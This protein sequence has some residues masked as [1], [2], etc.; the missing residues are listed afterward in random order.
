M[1]AFDHLPS[2]KKQGAGSPFDS[3]PGEAPEGVDPSQIDLNAPVGSEGFMGGVAGLGR[4]FA[5]GIISDLPKMVGEGINF[6]ADRPTEVGNAITEFGNQM[7]KATPGLNT[8]IIGQREA[9]NEWSVRGAAEKAGQ[10]AALSWGPGLAGAGV[11]A[12]AGS[13]IPGI[14]TIG[15]AGLGFIAG[16]LASLPFMAGQQG[17]ESQKKIEKAQLEKGATPEEAHDAARTGG[18]INAGI[19]GGMELAADAIPFKKILEPLAVIGKPIAKAAVRSIFEGGLKKAAKTVAATEAG[20]ISTEMMQQ[21]GESAVEGHFGAG[22][23]ATW[24]DTAQVILPTAIMS[25]FPGGFAAAHNFATVQQVKKTLGNG[26]ADPEARGAAAS[27]VFSQLKDEHPQAAQAFALY[28]RDQILAGRPVEIKDDDW[29]GD[30][31]VGKAKAQQFPTPDAPTNLLE[32]PG[33]ARLG[34]NP[35]DEDR[36]AAI[37]AA[38]AHADA[39]YAARDDFETQRAEWEA[40]NAEAAAVAGQPAAD[41]ELLAGLIN[42]QAAEAD[43]RA[44]AIELARQEALPSRQAGLDPAQGPITAMAAHAMDTGAT[45]LAAETR[46]GPIAQAE[47]ETHQTNIE[48]AAK[49]AAKGAPAGQ[50]KAATAPTSAPAAQ[51]PAAAAPAARTPPAPGWSREPMPTSFFPFPNAEG[52]A[53]RATALSQSLGEPYVAIPHPYQHDKFTVVPQAHE[54]AVMALQGGRAIP[55]APAA[56]AQPAAPARDDKSKSPEVKVPTPEAKT[57]TPEVKTAAPEAKQETAA[58]PP[59]PRKLEVKTKIVSAAAPWKAGPNQHTAADV[60]N[61]LV[62]GDNSGVDAIKDPD[63]RQALIERKM[64]GPKGLTP[65][66]AALRNSL[67]GD[68]SITSEGL[69]RQDAQAI[70]DRELGLKPP[71]ATAEEFHAADAAAE[72]AY[73]RSGGKGAWPEILDAITGDTDKPGGWDFENAGE[74]GRRVALLRAKEK[75]WQANADE[76]QTN[77]TRRALARDD[78]QEAAIAGPAA[79]QLEKT[80]ALPAPNPALDE[81]AHEAATSPKNDLAPPTKDQQAAG[82]YQK[83][84][85]TIGGL[86]FSI[87]NPEG[88]K[89]RPEWPALKHHYGYIKGTVGRDKD[90]LDAFIHPDTPDDYNGPV[91]IIDQIDPKT[92]KFDEHKIMVGFNTQQQAEFG[93]LDNYERGWKGLGDI[94]RVEWEGFKRW[95]K[96]GNTKAPFAPQHG[97]PAALPPVKAEVKKYEPAAGDNPVTTTGDVNPDVIPLEMDVSDFNEITDEW[98]AMFQPPGDERV[99]MADVVKGMEL[100]TPEQVAAQLEQWKEHAA[101]Q[102]AANSDRWVISLFDWTGQWS[103]PWVEAG[104][105]VIHLDLQDGVDI[106]DLSVEWFSENYPELTDVWAI[107]AAPPCTDF[108]SS[109]ARWMKEKDEDGRTAASI[110][111]VTQTLATIEYFRPAIWALENPV[112][113]IA[114]MTG[115]PP[116]RLTFDPNHFGDPYTKKTLLWG[117]FDAHLPALPVEATDGSKMHSKYGGKSQATKNARS[118]TPEGFAWSFFMQNNAEDM[119]PA[120]RLALLY[121]DASGAIKT[122][123]EAG[124]TAK[125]V[126]RIADE[127]YNYDDA[128]ETRDALAAAVKEKRGEAERPGLAKMK[129]AKAKLESPAADSIVNNEAPRIDAAPDERLVLIACSDA[130]GA[131]KA[132]A[133]D[134]Y[135][136]ALFEVLRKWMPKSAP[137]VAIVSAKHGLVFGDEELAPYDQKLTPERADELIAEGVPEGVEFAREVKDVFIAGSAE[138]QRVMRSLVAEMM[139][140]G[141]IAKDASINSTS[142]GIGTQRG[143]LADYLKTLAAYEKAAQVVKA[144]DAGAVSEDDF[145][146]LINEVQAERK[147]EP[148]AP[149]GLAKMQA[150]KKANEEARGPKK[151]PVTPQV[152]PLAGVSPLG[153]TKA[154]I[155]PTRA[156][157]QVQPIDQ[158]GNPVGPVKQAGKH[159]AE[160]IKEGFAGLDALFGRKGTLGSGPA[161]DEETWAKAK[162]HFEAAFAEFVAAGKSL[163]EFVRHILDVY[164]EAVIPYLKRWHQDKTQEARNEPNGNG[165]AGK[166]ALGGVASGKGGTAQSGRKSQ[167]GDSG[168]GNG[169]EPGSGGPN[170]AGVSTPRGRGSRTSNVHPPEAGTGSKRNAGRAGRAGRAGAGTSKD[171]GAPGRVNAPNIPAQNFR[172][173][174][175]V[176]LGQG[177]EAEKFADNLAAIRTLKAIEADNRRATP[178]EQRILARYIGWG[179]LAN[180][181]ADESNGEFKPGWKDRGEALAALLTPEEMRRARRSTQNAH[182]TSETIVG[183]MWQAAIQLGFKGGIALESS[184]GTGNFLGLVPDALAGSTRFIGAELDSVTARIA[185]LLYPQETV[186]NIGFHKMPMADNSVDLNIGNPP[187]GQGSLRFQFKPELQGKSIHNQFFIA[188]LDAVKPGGLQ[189]N[190]V[191]RF[192]LDAMDSSSRIE[193][194]KRARLIGAI[195]LPQSA[196]KENARTDVV[197]DILFLQKLTEAEQSRMASAFDAMNKPEKDREKERERRELIRSIPD[198]VNVQEIRDP[199]GGDPMPVNAYF[200]DNPHMILGTM[201]RSGTHQQHSDITVRVPKG[202]DLGAMLKKAIE[203]LPSDV[204]NQG[205][206]AIAASMERYKTLGEALKIAVDGHEPGALFAD[207]DG[208]LQQVFER[209]TPEG[210]YELARRELTAASPWSDTLMQNKDGKWY[211]LVQK[212]DDKGAPLKFVKDGKATKRNVYENEVFNSEADIPGG[213]LLGDADYA[214][215]RELV[216]LRDLLMTQIKYE[217]TDANPKEIE[218]NRRKLDAAYQAFVAK[219]GFVSRHTKLVSS[220]PDNGRILALEV[221]Y[222]PAISAEK[223]LK[224]GQKERPESAVPAPILKKRMLHKYEAATKAATPADALVIN[225]A[226]S[227]RVDIERIASLLGV[228]QD[229]AIKLLHDDIESPLIFKDPEKRAWVTRDEYLSGQV[230][231]KLEAAKAASLTKN[232]EALSTIQPE[233]WGAENVSVNLGA[234]WVPPAIYADFVKHLTGLDAVVRFAPVTNSYSIE[235]STDSVKAKDWGTA[236]MDAI[237]ILSHVMNSAAIKVYDVDNDGGRHLNQEQTSLA[238]LK[239]KEITGAFS[240]WVFENGDRRRALVSMFN[241]KYNTVVNRQ[242]DGSHLTLP[243]KVPDQI[244][245]MRPHQ[246]NAIWRGISE[247]FMLVDHAVGAGKTYMA[248]A[249]AMERRRMGLS[250]KPMIV[251]P[252]HMVEQFAQDVYRLYP[253]AKVLAAGKQDFERQRRRRLFGKIATGDWDIVIVPHSSFGFIGIAK[254]TEERYLDMELRIATQAVDDAWADSGETPNP[255]SNFRKPFNVKA[256]ERLKDKIE[257]RLDALQTGKRDNLFTFEQLGV[258]DLTIDEAHEFKNL[259]FSSGLTDVRGLGNRIGSRKAADLYNKVRVLRESPTGTV[260]FMSGT[261]ISNSA[262]EMYTLMRYLAADQLSDLGLEHFDAWRSQFANIDTKWEPTEFG[263]LKEVNRLGRQWTNMRSLMD[264][265]YTFTDAVTNEDIKRDY[266]IK[267][268]G[269]EFPI[270]RV[271]AGGRQLI[272]VPA[273]PAQIEFLQNII[274]GFDHLPQITNPID[275]NKERLRLMDRARKVSLDV[276]AVDRGS[277]SKEEG[278]KLEVMAKSI[279][280][281]YKKWTPDKGT[282]LVFLDRGVPKSKGDLTKIKAYDALVAEREAAVRAGNEAA[283]QSVTDKL[284]AYSADEIEELRAA[285]AGGWNAYEQLRDNLVARGVP[286]NEIR[287]IQSANTDAEKQ[288]LFDSVNAGEVRVLIGSTQRMG[289]GT[290]VQNKIVAIHHGDVTWKPSDIEQREGRGIRQNNSLLDK[291]GIDKFELEIYA[292]A[293][294]RSVEAKMWDLNA[295]KLRM[296]NGIRKYDGSFQMDFDDADSVSMAEMAAL[297]SGDPMLLKRVETASEI[298]TLM[299]QEREHRRKITGYKDAIDTAQNKLNRLPDRIASLRANAEDVRGRRALLE[300]EKS[301]RR[302]TIQGKE[303]AR[304]WDAAKAYRDEIVKQ[305]DGNEHARYEVEVNGKLLTTKE[306]IENAIASSLGDDSAFAMTIGNRTVLN[307]T[308]A[309]RMIAEKVRNTAETLE[310]GEGEKVPIDITFLGLPVEVKAFYSRWGYYASLS[311]KDKNGAELM[312]KMTNY[313][314][315]VEKLETT[316]IRPLVTEADSALS[317]SG[318]EFDARYEES[319]LARARAEL[320]EL[321]AKVSVPFAGAEALADARRRMEQIISGLA[322]PAAAPAAPDTSAAGPKLSLGSRGPGMQRGA[323]AHAISKIARNWKGGPKVEVVQSAS[324][325]PFPAPATARGAFWGGRV[326]LVADNIRSPE[327]AQFVLLHEAAGHYGLKAVLG[328]QLPWVMQSIYNSNANVRE[329]ADKRI[330]HAAQAGLAYD[331]T[332]ATE[333]ALADLAGAGQI[334]QVRGW[335]LLVAKV[336]ALLREFGFTIAVTDDEVALLLKKAS[337]SLGTTTAETDGPRMSLKAHPFYSAFQAGIGSAPWPK[338]GTMKSPQLKSWIDSRVRDGLFKQE[339]VNWLGIKEYLDLHPTVTKSEIAN[340]VSGRV[341]KVK[342]VIL[343]ARNTAWNGSSRESIEADLKDHGYRLE[344]D[345]GMMPGEAPAIIEIASDDW[346]A[347]DDVPEAVQNLLEQW[348]AA[349]VELHDTPTMFSKWQLPG[350]ANYTELLL[351]LEDN[352]RARAVRDMALGLTP[353]IVT[354]AKEFA[355][356]TNAEPD[357]LKPGDTA[358]IYTYPVPGNGLADGYYIEK[359]AG[360]LWIPDIDSDHY[361]ATHEEAAIQTAEM[362][363]R[364]IGLD[365]PKFKG[366][367]GGHF[368]EPNVIAHVRMNERIDDGGKRVLFVEEIQSDWAKAGRDNGFE[369]QQYKLPQQW[370]IAQEEGPLGQTWVVRNEAGDVVSTGDTQ[371]VAMHRIRVH[372]TGST[373]AAP[374]VQKTESWTMLALKRIVRYAA[375]NGFERVAWTTGNE[376]IDRYQTALRQRVSRIDWEHDDQTNNTF[377]SAY[378]NDDQNVFTGK[379]APNGR[380]T[381]GV[382]TGKTIMEVLGK[383]MADKIAAAPSGTMTGND[384]A[385]GGKGMRASY[386]EIIPQLANKLLRQLGGGEVVEVRIPFN[387]KTMEGTARKI[388]AP[389]ANMLV[390]GAPHMG[391][392]VTPAMVEKAMA[393]QPMFSLDGIMGAGIEAVKATFDN[394]R[395]FNWWHRTVGTQFHKAQAVPAFRPVFEASQRY[396]QDVSQLAIDASDK[397]LDW[398]PRLASASDVLNIFSGPKKADMAAASKIL[399]EG[400]LTKKRP[401]AIALR[402]LTKPQRSLYTQARAAIDLSLE[403]VAKSELHKLTQDEDIEGARRRAKE[404]PIHAALAHLTNALADQLDVLQSTGGKQQDINRKARL[405]DQMQ[406]VVDK[407][408]KLKAEGYV[409]LMRFGKYAVDVTHTEL[410]K[411]GQPVTVR[412]YFGM[413][414]SNREAA[415]A[416]RRAAADFP[417]SEVKRSTMDD[418]SWKLFQGLSLDSLHTF[419]DASGM[420]EHHLFQEYYK[421]AVSAR[422]ALTRLIHRKGIAG[423][424]EDMQRVLAS[425]ITSNARLASRNYHF[426]EMQRAATR[427]PNEFGDVKEEAAK[428]VSYVQNPVEEAHAVRGLLFVNFLGGSIASALTNATQPVLMTLPYLSR[429]GGAAQAARELAAAAGIAAGN[430]PADARLRAAMDRAAAEGI[431]EPQE[432]HQLYAES[433]RGLGS[434]LPVRRVLKAWGSMFSLAESF[435]RRITFAAAF[436]IAQKQGMKDPFTFAEKAVEDTQGIYNRGNRPNWARGTIGATVFTFKQYSIAYLEFIKRLPPKE[437]AIAGALLILA[438]GVQGLPGADDLEDLIDTIGQM[439]GYNTNSKQS[440]REFAIDVLGDQLGPLVMHGVSGLPGSPVD[441]QQRLGLSNIVPGTGLFMRSNPDKTREIAEFVG[442]IGGVYTQAARA[443]EALQA[444]APGRALQQGT[445]IAAQNV[446]RGYEMWQ[447]GE[448]K[449]AAGRKVADVTPTDAAFKAIGLQPA[450]V[451]AKQRVAGDVQQSIRMVRVVEQGIA[452]RWTRGIIDQKPEEVQRAVAELHA[453]N[454]A[455][456]EWKILISPAQIKAR[457]EATKISRDVRLMKSA[458][459]EVRANVLRILNGT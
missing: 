343:G 205:D 28:A 290:N 211:R 176:R 282:Q 437:K 114:N 105:N 160:G 457:V 267:H 65:K 421:L 48:T 198:W 306:G 12:A 261:P 92:G 173:T 53:R 46:A 218:A 85:H 188:G 44:A 294:E 431:T 280:D 422:S 430:V 427:I 363:D 409:P 271:A 428:L 445:P 158:A 274:H 181:F 424:N 238:L 172:I 107:L 347:F 341:F 49:E 174:S 336:R 240:E 361:P 440:I 195:R 112:G 446:M 364:I 413:F 253:G 91:Y 315:K 19:E 14:G 179:G 16:S 397:A 168:S 287:F 293:T 357:T 183:S 453:W 260:T 194:A 204:M 94:K 144:E 13:V 273:T 133:I 79:P 115:L 398:L 60:L 399:F 59:T 61:S 156:G 442:P 72:E 232:I 120:K 77:A 17:A 62:D 411:E 417:K 149:T 40:Q 154:R 131:A 381:Q 369:G 394:P 139:D 456:P 239:A 256:A 272:K 319:A 50:P 155:I 258:D 338:S 263:R 265:Y 110:E 269:A 100:M 325:L 418:E 42:Q 90:H 39:V 415:A 178:E 15:G 4:T 303:Y 98:A 309:A 366:Y 221:E 276:R 206:D 83:G 368:H 441:V 214:T 32:G 125:E 132:P 266:A 130:K 298:E 135:Q 304:E 119:D 199:L 301:K 362:M 177:G 359:A 455:N 443:V 223:A 1:G 346:V 29:Y 27:M 324:Q 451:G 458:P 126:E 99:R 307:R 96:E 454:L 321:Q 292:Y 425:F 241:E 118:E 264:L 180:A 300:E 122:S 277:S 3:L 244:I 134:L 57:A 209:E 378:D 379:A 84:H 296:V 163:K 406:E 289:A 20:E 142:G 38:Q 109:G 432:L 146:A 80:A 358:Y 169:G 108:A 95:L 18:W 247:R 166:E 452:D 33:G 184:M 75:E 344:E 337:D 295:T 275:R 225:L 164:N 56:V 242:H 227:G 355:R 246:L 329:M 352:A 310:E 66:G 351:Q 153:A 43:E 255:R 36:Q 349:S 63:I 297:A 51:P 190:V 7:D 360:G 254:E 88:S 23:G 82:N 389:V 407:S 299:L 412:D 396:L 150:A 248:I 41:R 228:K 45:Q 222:Y 121:P 147:A 30:Y 106:N 449:D 384:L 400:T 340:Y 438:A 123:L 148:P 281:I 372:S 207:E 200:A 58:A 22:E 229:E 2:D 435:N 104:Y 436:S 317:P 9:G 331:I 243:G 143:Q 187:F 233:P 391:F 312:S 439:L 419:A 350:G 34:H 370:T 448:Y 348:M 140:A 388:V 186:L 314:D 385:I 219:R 374:F 320:P 151:A 171:D 197:T 224:T 93:Y 101:K 383:E 322:G 392:D 262:V 35:T 189:I 234:S 328:A 257:A 182:Y 196:F 414:E 459:P 210:G 212:F 259:F 434:S 423:Y 278:G 326:W 70:V 450:T 113:R 342:D 103:A 230:R 318:M 129:K 429:F 235:G 302:V 245:Q 447:T 89:R 141:M 237:T 138:Y 220:M 24:K 402:N 335:K 165:V 283:F 117:R 323:V 332:R 330:A 356:L 286:S 395:Q 161:F 87:E 136:G 339:E 226:E 162:P 203:S 250:R 377:V 25:L 128:K 64:I 78:E 236:R 313:H 8:S 167:R 21:A 251:V 231:R 213:L 145:D 159:V 268:N 371:S 401:D 137:G 380:F 217:S 102:K 11:G 386:D 157:I 252:N 390:G 284:E 365:L 426:G 345:L 37:D 202:A 69:S 5:K 444:G 68:R 373:P 305:Q 288:A 193:L 420:R 311:M 152:P 76:L 405:L 54:A 382:A 201:D 55:R 191:S 353:K 127:T 354:D 404:M 86:D 81:A 316:A 334:A 185:K 10:S 111:L 408:D 47:A 175:D 97:T 192:L 375:E 308:A 393:G 291:Y 285:Q 74:R 279:A 433:I 249:R 270:P 116:A 26:D 170:G 403:Q 367:Y 376:Q 410:N 208:K 327:A 387:R 124:L 416:A 71:K 333:E 216:N 215:L 6:V 31:L 73:R 52:A 67:A